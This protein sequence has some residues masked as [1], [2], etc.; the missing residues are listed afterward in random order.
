MERGQEDQVDGCAHRGVDA[1]PLSLYGL[2]ARLTAPTLHRFLTVVLI[3]LLAAA[4]FISGLNSGYRLHP[5]EAL[6]ASYGRR[7]AHGDLLLTGVP[8]D[9]PPL[10]F[11]A[12]GLSFQL[13]GVSE[14]AARIPSV[15]ATLLTLA[16]A[17]RLVMRLYDQRVALV[18]VFLLAISPMV[19]AFAATAFT[20]PLL[21]C[22][23]VLGVLCT[24]QRRWGWSGVAL[25]LAFAVKPSALQWLPL[26]VLLG[27][28]AERYLNW[29]HLWQFALCFGLILT[30]LT[31]WQLARDTA[32]DFW[33]LNNINNNPGRF[34]R[35]EEV[36]P[37]L[38]RW[39]QYALAVFPLFM[40][41]WLSV[42][43]NGTVSAG[44]EDPILLDLILTAY[45]L[46]SMALLWLVAFNTYDRYV[47]PLVPFLL[48]LVAR[49][50][51]RVGV[52]RGVII[53]SI[54]VALFTPPVHL[55]GADGSY[56]GIDR[57][58][59]TLNTLPL[60]SIVYEHWLGWELGFYLGEQPKIQLVWLPTVRELIESP[61]PCYFVAPLAESRAW[62]DELSSA[63]II[64]Q[65]FYI[66]GRF[67]V[68]QVGTL[69]K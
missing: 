18:T 58:A 66:S 67:G 48:I 37:R 69:P 41:G 4:F 14:F 3:L 1:A 39:G 57:L 24:V 32:P 59:E 23:I 21:T 20:D 62:L 64:F 30:L 12:L 38:E 22:F 5:D 56:D 53:A 34:I 45:T 15:F 35:A 61:K 11:Y 49:V 65:T 60:G 63:G 17:Y 7:V 31:V 13:F 36:A 54:A 55:G 19:R 10:L 29:R 50:L 42:V 68:F 27:I 46:G 47:L 2:N 16:A 43:I 8:L 44:S 9:K 40:I 6:Y 33:T 51:V 28:V 26:T 25:G 52:I